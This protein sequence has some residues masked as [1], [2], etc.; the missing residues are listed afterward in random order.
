MKIIQKDIEKYHSTFYHIKHYSLI[1]LLVFSFAL[2]NSYCQ[3]TI[4]KILPEDS[5]PGTFFGQFLKWNDN[6]AIISAHL[7]FENGTASGSV[8]FF[9]EKENIFDQT[10]KYYPNDG[11]IEDYFGYSIS[12]YGDF[13]IAGAHHDS[14]KGASSG[15]A[16]I[17]KRNE[18]AWTLFQKIVPDDGKEA[19]EFG[20]TVSMYGTW[21]AICAY[22]NDDKGINSGCV[23]L[24]HFDGTEW[25]FHSKIFPDNSE[26]YSMFGI[27]IDMNDNLLIVGAP[28]QNGFGND[29]GTAYIFSFRNNLWQQEKELKPISL[30]DLDQY[31]SEVKIT[32]EFAFVSAIKDDGKG[33]NSG[34]VYV[35][36]NE[37]DSNWVI[38]Q[39]IAPDDLLQGD[40][41]GISLDANES[42]LFIGSYFDDDKG[43]NSGSVYYYRLINDHWKLIKKI[44]PD[45]VNESDAFGSSVSLGQNGLLAGAYSDDT[46]GFF[47]GAAYFIPRTLI[48][49]YSLDV[50]IISQN[51]IKVFPSLFFDHL[52]ILNLVPFE[53]IEYNLINMNG[54]II[55][56]GVFKRDSL[57]LDM[58]DFPAGIYIL[59]IRQNKNF[60]N[61][62][63]VKTKF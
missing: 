19:D 24:Y 58:K 54:F 60:S 1:T 29:S 31:G 5:R 43:T 23:Y 49:S 20:N 53:N 51:D 15:A 46:N 14:D 44:I 47:S 45:E 17:L 18:N 6:T 52:N 56:N 9:D 25:K 40:G 13:M 38:Q 4:V 55:K 61:F 50:E 62:K 57:T 27:T 2:K 34:A 11:A 22:L 3:N 39:K 26:P 8:Y 59:Q 36:K 10:Q 32:K 30:N 35:F 37:S 33:L 16:Y 42:E 21:A 12:T 63:L 7:D 41:F 28:L 48:N